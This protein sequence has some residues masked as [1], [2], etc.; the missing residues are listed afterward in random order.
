MDRISSKITLEFTQ[1]VER[2][3][4]CLGWRNEDIS[5]IFFSDNG[6]IREGYHCASG[7]TF[8]NKGGGSQL[9]STVP[10]SVVFS[11]STALINPSTSSLSNPGS[12]I[13]SSVGFILCQIIKP[14]ARF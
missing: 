7:M 3:E 14:Y 2:R 5:L 6:H 1:Q 12:S 11:Y 4:K 8:L 10:L 9:K 13:N